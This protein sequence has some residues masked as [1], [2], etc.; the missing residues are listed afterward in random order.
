MEV[1]FNSVRQAVRLPNFFN[2]HLVLDTWTPLNF[3]KYDIHSWLLTDEWNQV[4]IEAIW[5]PDTLP[6]WIK[7]NL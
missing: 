5:Q 7:E 1:F 4:E 3:T 2:F 6:N